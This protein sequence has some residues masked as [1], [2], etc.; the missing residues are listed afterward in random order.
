M[1]GTCDVTVA[2]STWRYGARD[3]VRTDTTVVKKAYERQELSEAETG[4]SYIGSADVAA[5]ATSIADRLQ[6]LGRLSS[7]D[8]ANVTASRGLF[9]S[10][11]TYLF[12]WGTW[13]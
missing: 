5:R 12:F 3:R 13:R 7:E 2:G 4:P 11:Y 8:V 1:R 9:L 6:F 10:N